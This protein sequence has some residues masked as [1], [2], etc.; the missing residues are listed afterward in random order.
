VRDDQLCAG[1]GG[2]CGVEKG[3]LWISLFCSEDCR[4]RC[5]MVKFTQSIGIWN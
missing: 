2:C 4:L 5:E 3:W 1:N